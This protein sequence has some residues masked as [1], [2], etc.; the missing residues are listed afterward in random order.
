M[1][2]GKGLG[3]AHILLLVL[4]LFVGYLIYT[5][6]AGFV[7]NVII[8]QDEDETYYLLHEKDTFTNFDAAYLFNMAM[9]I[10]GSIE[11]K[12]G[13]Y[14]LT[15]PIT[16]KSNIYMKLPSGAIIT[17]NQP[18]S[19]EQSISLLWTEQYVENVVIDGGTW[20]GK[21]GSL[22]DSWWI[23]QNRWNANFKNYM[24][25]CFYGTG[26]NIVVKN[27]YIH[28]VI[29]RGIDFMG[30]TN[31]WIQNNVIIDAG[32]NP[33]TIDL[34]CFNVIAEYNKVT[35][36]QDVGINTFHANNCFIRHNEVKYVMQEVH[37][38]HWGI[39]AENSVG[40]DITDNTVSG[41]SCNI[42]VTASNDVYVANN[43]I[44]GTAN[45]GWNYGVQAM[46]N[47]YDVTVQ[48]NTII[49][50]RR[51][52]GTY[53]AGDNCHD[54][55]FIDNVCQGFGNNPA[56]EIMG[57]TI[58][59]QGGSIESRSSEGC[60]FLNQAQNVEVRSVKFVGTNGIWDYLTRSDGVTITGC[61]FT[62]LS[63]TKVSV[64]YC[65]N[66]NIYN[67]EGYP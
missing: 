40:I 46:S 12:D 29:A 26:Q 41:C 6:Y 50:C 57:R 3:T 25:I 13:N 49:N 39:A 23:D 16:P 48:G 2:R 45:Q 10:G 19:L 53:P 34:N 38:S 67:N 43:I 18:T 56:C 59:I 63:G 42:A 4:A 51:P 21:K 8:G 35:G 22:Y 27:A 66:V 9:D 32:D 55:D 11:V 44:D 58:L 61:D 17:Q 36:G 31:G 60:I 28:D 24:G 20:D 52:L 30:I 7:P 62:Q 37:S 54:I 1:A 5:N 47:T 14:L 64:T 33:I 65:S 15:H